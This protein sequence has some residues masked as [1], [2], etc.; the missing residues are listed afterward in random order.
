MR[1]HAILWK[2]QRPVELSG[3][4]EGNM[5]GGVDRI[6]HIGIA[7]PDLAAAAAAFER[8]GFLLTPLSQQAGPLSLDGP[9]A[10]WGSANRCVMLEAGY[11]ELIGI[12][13]PS[14]YD[15]ELGRFLARYH[16]IPVLALG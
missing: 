3:E 5:S 12:V 14:L 2:G 15:N 9:V 7:V 6:D 8:L 16:G 10:R 13:D 11:I 4:L 1:H